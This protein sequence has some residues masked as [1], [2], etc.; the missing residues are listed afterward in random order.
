MLDRN[1]SSCIDHAKPIKISFLGD[2]MCESPLLKAAFVDGGYNFEGV[3]E[4]L[5]SLFESSDYVVGNLETPLAGRKLKYTDS[6]YSF[7]SPE[8]FGLSVKR[9]GVDLVL[10]A[11]NHCCDRGI[12]GLRRTIDALDRLELSHTGTFKD[13][14]VNSPFIVEVKGSRF[15]F[16]S[17]TASTNANRTKCAPTL[18]NVNL[19]DEQSVTLDAGL[20]VR[21]KTGIV[22]HLIGEERYAKYRKK[23]GLTPKKIS[24]DNS[25]DKTRVDL[26]LDNIAGQ[27]RKVQEEADY[28]FVCPHMGGQFNETPG[29]FSEYVMDRLSKLGVS[30]IVSSHPHV[31]QK[32]ELINGVPCA[33][34]L[35]N[36]SMSLSTPYIVRD[37]MPECGIV[38][39]FYCLDRVIQKITITPTKI[40]E[41]DSGY[42][43][44]ETY[45][46]LFACAEDH[47]RG[48]LIDEYRRILRVVGA[49]EYEIEASGLPEEILLFEF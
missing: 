10:T 9:C 41:E 16:I 35:G 44:V 11:N 3:F 14:E 30:G 28:V 26:Y 37:N 22:R 29:L 36:V 25:I 2:I 45:S 27:V 48:Q 8:E 13:S 15:A 49:L 20:M 32:C 46:A 42:L 43:R 23:K 4:G 6:M 17:C 39:H 24:V 7:N 12:E 40:I 5:E 38:L 34:S 18:L 31:V 1:E 33:F 19:L 21:L 47:E